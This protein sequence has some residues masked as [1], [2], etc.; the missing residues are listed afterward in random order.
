MAE[1]G[2]YLYAIG[3]GLTDED[4]AGVT[5]LQGGRLE[6]VERNG[7]TAI[8]ST[9]DLDEFGEEGLRR[10]LEDLTWLEAVARTH[11]AVVHEAASRTPTAPLRLATVCLGDDQVRARLDEWREALERTL[12]RI[13][14]RM[15]WSVKT[16][17]PEVVAQAT[18]PVDAPTG[19]GAGAAYLRRRK[20]ATTQRESANEAAARVADEIHAALS[21]HAVAGRRLPPQDRRLT[22]HEGTMTLNGAYLVES[23]SADQFRAAAEAL[24]T[25]HAEL[26]LD[27]QGPWPPYSFA[28][29]DDG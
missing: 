26:R 4:L 28:T 23:P 24:G 12:D 10:N 5:G 20:E 1:T 9:V 29:L 8:V 16:F 13:T 22:G 25:E 2:R 27:V 18:A 14:G 17:A 19:A 7:L 15:E 21:A 3:R 11:D 6:V